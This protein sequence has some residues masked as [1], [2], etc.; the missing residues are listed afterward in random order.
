MPEPPSHPPKSVFSIEKYIRS[1][2]RY[3]IGAAIIMTLL[4]G[5]TYATV[6]IALDRH[7]IQQEIS[8]LSGRQFIRFQQLANQTR[9]VMRAS[10]DPDIPEYIITP[11]LEEIRETIAD[12]RATMLLLERDQE[13]LN[14]NLL[15][16][17]SSRGSGQEDI[18]LELNWRLEEFLSRAER[19]IDSSHEDRKRRYAFWGPIDF[20]ATADGHLMRHFNSIIKYSHGRSVSSIDNAKSL[21]TALLLMLASVLILAS[22]FLFFPLLRRLRSEHRRK[23]NYESELAHL[24]QTDSLTALRN[25]AYFN[26]ALRTLLRRYSVNGKGFSLLLVD[27]D[28][29]KSINDSFG[30]PAGD[31]TLLHVAHAF[32]SVFRSD[33][34]IARIGGDEFA[35]LLPELDDERTFNAI[36]ERVAGTIASEFQFE[37]NTLRIS[38]SVGG[39]MVPYHATDEAG[40]IR[41][42]DL[43]LYAAKSE[44]NRAV[45]FDKDALALQLEQSELSAALVCAADRDEF[46]V[47]YQ[48][49]VCLYSGHHL[50]FE[51][52]VRW[53]HPTLGLLAPGAFLPL[54]EDPRL[55]GEM[56]R[57][58]ARGV[59]C[60]LLAWKQAGYTPGPVAINLPEA[61]LI[62]DNG[63]EMLAS[64]IHEHGLDWSD[65]AVEVTEDVFLN[66]YADLMRATMTCFRQYG[67][68]IALDDFGTGF[69][70]LLHLRDFPF[71]ELKIDR[72][73]IADIG[74]D[75]RSEQII[76]AM[77][78]L[79]RNLGKRCVAEGIETQ[80]QRHFLLELGCEV[81]QGYLFAKPMPGSEVADRWFNAPGAGGRRK[82][83]K[84]EC[85][86]ATATDSHDTSAKAEPR[87]PT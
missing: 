50:G 84:K 85:A 47:H 23:M 66:R 2:G 36:A 29:F 65:I 56:T 26:S 19:I 54:M 13:M 80:A 72:G 76:R 55:I 60:D 7:A 20:A 6:R 28:H 14:K 40:L 83:E 63:F 5:A 49:K 30:H 35:I 3:Y 46:V 53:Q 51:A 4:I 62:N 18:Y 57:A 39:A 52:L 87:T 27:L 31:A 61:L 73:F 82:V 81:A 68:S 15:E 64:A 33:D 8:F 75:D 77:V 25:R 59:C 32:R 45:I 21:I 38:A 37:G 78:D 42:A 34:V 86:A 22:A 48:P 74:L 10:A 44:R 12:L 17:I 71:D 1:I 41:V 24:A 16:R 70:S 69:A 67:V 9:A 11:M 58:V 79:S 43:A